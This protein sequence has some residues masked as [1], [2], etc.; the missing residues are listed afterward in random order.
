MHQERDDLDKIIAHSFEEISIDYRNGEQYNKR[1]MAKLHNEKN[2][3]GKFRT[4]AISLIAAGFLL[5]FMYTSNVQYGITNIECKIKT[6]LSVVKNNI[7]IDKYF[8]GE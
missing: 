7:N 1:L 2:S 4:V 8:L 3:V 5:G 6:D